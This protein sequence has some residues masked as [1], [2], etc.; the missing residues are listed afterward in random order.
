MDITPFVTAELR[1]AEIAWL[2]DISRITAHTWLRKNNPAKPHRMIRARVAEVLG[3]VDRALL[4]GALPYKGDS[5][6]LTKTRDGYNL[7]VEVLDIVRKF[8]AE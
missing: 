6:H 4:T 7:R 1:P 3:A 2:C 8:L 5:P